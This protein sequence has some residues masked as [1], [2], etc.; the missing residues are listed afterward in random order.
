MVSVPKKEDLSTK[1]Q[2]GARKD[3]LRHEAM[4]SKLDSSNTLSSSRAGNWVEELLDSLGI[5]KPRF[6]QETGDPSYHPGRCARLWVGET[7]LGT[8]GQIH[9]QVMKNYAV[10]A[11]FYCAQISFEELFRLQGGT[12]VFKPLPR[13]PAVT[14]DIAVICDIRI[15]VGEMEHV[16]LESGGE[17]LT[18]CSVFD[19]YTG[20]HIVEGKKSVAFSLTMRAEDQTLTDEHAEEI[21]R[22]VLEALKEKFSAEMR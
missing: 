13:F 5:R 18:D 16:I 10:D 1:G 4:G 12:P 9:P 7:C 19:V 6:V 8:L 15:P 22:R 14:R 21:V 11:E 20:H 17:Y 2:S 3:R